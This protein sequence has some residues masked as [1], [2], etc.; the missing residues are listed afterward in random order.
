MNLYAV[1]SQSH[2]TFICPD[3][4]K[5]LKTIHSSQPGNGMFVTKNR[6]DHLLPPVLLAITNC[7][8]NFEKK[9]HQF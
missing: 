6:N 5:C 1:G 9:I 4:K 3:V 2:V 7:E 8:I